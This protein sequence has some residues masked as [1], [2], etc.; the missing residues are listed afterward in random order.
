MCEQKITLMLRSESLFK[1]NFGV[2]LLYLFILWQHLPQTAAARDIPMPV[3]PEVGS[4]KRVPSFARPFFSASNTIVY[5]MRSFIE[6]PGFRNSH[7]ATKIINLINN[8][9]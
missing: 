3:F 9:L 2:I 4:T 6:P 7:F 5:E 8:L 1:S